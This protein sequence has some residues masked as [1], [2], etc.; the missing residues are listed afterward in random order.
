MAITNDNGWE[1]FPH[2]VLR[3]T[4]F[5]FE[6]VEQLQFEKTIEAFSHSN[7]SNDAVQLIFE[8]EL[9]E[10]RLNLKKCFDSES[11]RE[12]LLIS[13]PDMNQHIERYINYFDLEKRTSKIKRIEKKLFTYL[14]R[15][16]GKNESASFF[17]PLNY[18]EFDDEI[19]DYWQGQL[20]QERFI[21]KR[22]SFLSYWAVKE[23]Q[24][25]L[26]EDQKMMPFVPIHLREGQ[27]IIE[28]F[29]WFSMLNKK[30]KLPKS[31]LEVL[32]K[33]KD[34]SPSLQELKS[35]LEEAESRQVDQVVKALLDKGIIQHQWN[36]PSS[37]PHPLNDY[38]RQ[39]EKTPECDRKQHWLQLLNEFKKEV[40]LIANLNIAEK[41]QQIKRLEL[42]FEE[43][44]GKP[45]RRGKASLYADRFIYYEDAHGHVTDFRFGKPFITEMKQKLSGALNISAFYGEEIWNY[46]QE[47]GKHV[48][49]STMNQS[50]NHTAQEKIPFLSF[51]QLLREQ[52]EDTP[53]IPT[54]SLETQILHQIQKHGVEKAEVM[55]SEQDLDFELSNRTFYSLPDV[56]I[57]AK[58][59]QELK[60]GKGTIILAKLHHHLLMNNWMTYFHKDTDRLQADLQQVLTKMKTSDDATLAGIEV[61]RRNKAYYD[62]PGTVAVYAEQP[63]EGKQT[64]HFSDLEVVLDPSIN[65]LMLTTKEG[66]KVE[67]YI[68]LADQVGYLPF[69]MFTK[70]PLHR[71]PIDSGQHTPR[72]IIDGIVYQRERWKYEDTQELVEWFGRLKDL[73]LLREVWKWREEEGIHSVVYVKGSDIRKPYLIDFKNFFSVELF[74]QI[75]SQNKNII[76]EEM[77][78]DP[79]HLWLQ[80]GKGKHS[81]ELRLALYK[82]KAGEDQLH[83]KE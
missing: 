17:G 36:I 83:E 8:Q 19:D 79:E 55:I 54:S 78:P 11:F 60:E 58:N 66:E 18:G 1:V 20:N 15:L 32:Q 48:F 52:Y 24:A 57:Q 69:A 62:Y 74:Q 40:A 9:S 10:K 63:A 29:L 16:C 12:A 37:I 44:T 13:N 6:W 23:L 75:L 50:T 25:A 53:H 59:T 22:E 77:F 14:Q 30:I 4:G 81:T 72:V 45:S 46:Y 26:I 76:I 35:D 3:S 39:V 33:I 27:E 80:T 73:E 43:L 67:L 47:L 41:E 49:H 70:P 51:I 7:N 61:R 21:T 82:I 42:R 65:E 34:Q 71:I 2:F 31:Y 56:F 64:I 68:P 28:N 38:I 5:P